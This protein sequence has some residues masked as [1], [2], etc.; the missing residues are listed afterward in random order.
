[1]ENT[2]SYFKPEH[3]G[4][5]NHTLWVPPVKKTYYIISIYVIFSIS[6]FIRI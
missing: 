6:N 4:K 5:V 3:G 2:L 1:M